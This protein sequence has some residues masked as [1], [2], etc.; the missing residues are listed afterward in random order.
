MS[1]PPYSFLAAEYGVSCHK[2]TSVDGNLTNEISIS[3]TPSQFL[4]EQLI[5][6][7]CV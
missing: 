7:D 5:F 4:Y 1:A 3:V 6:C 2:L